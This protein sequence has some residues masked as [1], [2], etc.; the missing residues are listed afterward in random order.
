MRNSVFFQYRFILAVHRLLPLYV[1]CWH[2]APGCFVFR[3]CALRAARSVHSARAP[4]FTFA[5]KSHAPRIGASCKTQITPSRA[6]PTVQLA[7]VHASESGLSISL[8]LTV[9]NSNPYF[10]PCEILTSNRNIRLDIVILWPFVQKLG[11]Y[12]K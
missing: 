11:K 7:T 5:P 10:S 12:L 1:S 3:S 8:A 6:V 9:V 4:P 2:V